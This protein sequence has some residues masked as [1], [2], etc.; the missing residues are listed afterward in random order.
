[1]LTATDERA[2]H[3]HR[4]M[5]LAVRAA[6]LAEFAELWQ[7]IEPEGDLDRG[8]PIWLRAVWPLLRVWFDTSARQARDYWLEAGGDPAH[9][10]A[11]S[12]DPDQAIGSLLVTGPGQVRTS[13]RLGRSPAQAGRDGL[14]SASRSAGRLVLA[15]GRDTVEQAARADPTVTRWQR[16]TDGDPCE[17]CAMLAGRGA[18]YLSERTA[19]GT[20]KRELADL[21][22]YHDGCGC[23]VAPVRVAAPPRRRRRSRSRR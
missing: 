23:T 6:F 15:G 8:I 10:P 1:M 4:D 22:R 11:V 19:S 16:I 3:A 5:Q 17:F 18:V 12:F 20:D 13:R 21:A 14:A 9:L 2:A 7:L